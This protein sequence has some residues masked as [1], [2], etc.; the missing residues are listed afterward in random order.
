MSKCNK[1]LKC[2]VC[3]NTKDIKELQ[4]EIIKLQEQINLIAQ[5][6]GED[7]NL[8]S[9]SNPI[10]NI[11]T[12][13]LVSSD[14]SL[15][16]YNLDDATAALDPSFG[17]FP[18][19]W[20]K[21]I[22][23]PLSSFRTYHY[24]LK[25]PEWIE[26]GVQNN[27]RVMIGI[28]L[29]DYEAELNQLSSDYI[30]ANQILKSQ[31]DS[32]VIAIAIGNEEPP[33]KISDLNNGM[34]Y[35]KN[36]R[37]KLPRNAL[38]TTVLAESNTK[39]P[40]EPLPYWIDPT[41]PPMNAVFTNNFLTLSPNLEI[42]CFNLYG[43]YYTSSVPIDVR[44]SWNDPSVT[45]NEFAAVRFAMEKTNLTQPFWCTEI[46]WQSS[47]DIPGSTIPNLEA[48]YTNFLKFNIKNPNGFY[49]AQSTVT[50]YSPDRI[51]YF[52]IRDANNETF[53]IYTANQSL[54][55]KF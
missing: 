10:N 52:T 8:G 24:T 15:K 48:F 51:F 31:Y 39:T 7:V 44:L 17:S 37:G 53:G 35:A 38:I 36:L 40:N 55:P 29:K 49:S 46:G 33:S 50:T 20:L 12:D 9:P 54:T 6:T 14:F 45:L 4:K 1:C 2:Q 19:F 3:K 22:N 5:I 32:Y 34:L 30:A 42:I 28:T 16:G 23:S 47:G 41:F 18:Q 43:G 13:N 11:F 25:T 21:T 27:L 26:W